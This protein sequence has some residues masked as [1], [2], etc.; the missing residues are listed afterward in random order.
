MTNQGPFDNNN[1]PQ[2]SLSYELL[3]LLQWM[4][5]H[6]YETFKKIITRALKDTARQ[7]GKP[8]LPK[9]RPGDEEAHYSIIDFFT[10]LDTA[11]MAV[12]N[13]DTAQQSLQKALL[14]ALDKIDMHM[15]D[16]TTVAFAAANALSK[17][18]RNPRSNP[19]ELLYKELLKRWK[20][21][22]KSCMH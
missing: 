13:E 20:P 21:A 7:R 22:K 19:E 3:Y 6:E 12:L 11:L 17:F 18:E 2:F 14:P 5:E 10:L 1:P 8:M 4:V 9:D 15:C 16:N